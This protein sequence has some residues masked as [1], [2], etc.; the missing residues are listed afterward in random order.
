MST[1]CQIAFYKKDEKDLNNFKALIYKHH[2]GY[3][4]DILP[5][6]YKILKPFNEERGVADIEYASAW[7]VSQLKE[8]YLDVGICKDFH[9]DIEYLYAIYEDG[10]IEYF[11]TDFNLNAEGGKDI[12]QRSG[13]LGEIKLTDNKEDLKDLNLKLINTPSSLF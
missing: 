10:T 9:G 5:S 8:D 13:K 4:E 7:L 6:L 2:D 1:R 11:E 12:N 3:P